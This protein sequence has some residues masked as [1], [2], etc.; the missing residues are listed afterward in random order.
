MG[1]TP[2]GLY[3]PSHAHISSFGFDGIGNYLSAINSQGVSSTAWPLA[4]L[5]LYVPVVVPYSVLVTGVFWVAGA[6]AGG[7]IDIGLYQENGT[8]VVSLGSTSRGTAS[9]INSSF[10]LTDTTVTPGRYYLAMA[11]DSTNTEQASA[12]AAGL[13]EAIG[14]NE[15]QTAFALPATATYTRTTRAYLPL[16]GLLLGGTVAP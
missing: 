16:F 10:A 1:W 12:P 11:A 3:L 4:N 5:A 8:K 6:T 14:I 15:Q 2:S 13:L 9:A 7:N